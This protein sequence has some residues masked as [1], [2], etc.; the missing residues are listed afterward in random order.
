MAEQYDLVIEF[1]SDNWPHITMVLALM[2]VVYLFVFKRIHC[3]LPYITR[4]TIHG[5]LNSEMTFQMSRLFHPLKV[6]QLKLDRPLE[7]LDLSGASSRIDYFPT[8][9][10]VTSM[11]SNPFIRAYMETKGV[12]CK[13]AVFKEFI[14]ASIDNLEDLESESFDSV[15]SFQTLCSVGEPEIVL[16]EI[17][18]IL[19]PV[20]ILFNFCGLIYFKSLLSYILVI[21]YLN[22][23][24]I[25]NGIFILRIVCVQGFQYN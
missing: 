16:Q 14:E 6:E 3:Y 5:S 20:S 2:L 18:R 25:Y 17:L 19:R 9:C 13:Q 22:R 7:I 15:V 4:K 21:F 23:L 24:Q 11:D 1:L 12:E 8:D 10:H